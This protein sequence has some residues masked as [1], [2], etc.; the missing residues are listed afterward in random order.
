MVPWQQTFSRMYYADLSFLAASLVFDIRKLLRMKVDIV[1]S[2]IS[3]GDRNPLNEA[4][5]NVWDFLVP[6]D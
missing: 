5:Q 6:F 1:R 4:L 3:S 2:C